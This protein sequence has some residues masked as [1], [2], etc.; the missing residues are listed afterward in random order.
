MTNVYIIRKAKI[1]QWG[2][3]ITCKNYHN[4]A[5]SVEAAINYLKDR[6]G[7]SVRYIVRKEKEN[8]SDKD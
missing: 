2:Y 5:P 7:S 8:A 4:I 6:Y 1:K 3:E